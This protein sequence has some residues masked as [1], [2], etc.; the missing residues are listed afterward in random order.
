VWTLG[1]GLLDGL[2]G[3]PRVDALMSGQA[4]IVHPKGWSLG[5]R[6]VVAWDHPEAPWSQVAA[7]MRG[8]RLWMVPEWTGGRPLGP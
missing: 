5:K 4:S 2:S 8:G 7:T 1:L 3:H 6:P